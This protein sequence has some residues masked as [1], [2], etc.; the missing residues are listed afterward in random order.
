M[1]LTTSKEH[2]LI[3]CELALVT[4]HIVIT[5]VVIPHSSRIK[6]NNTIVRRSHKEPAYSIKEG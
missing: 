1:N 5:R 4:R 3:A 6:T 2:V